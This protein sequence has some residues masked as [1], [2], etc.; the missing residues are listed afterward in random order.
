MQKTDLA[1]RSILAEAFAFTQGAAAIEAAQEQA[2]IAPYQKQVDDITELIAAQRGLGASESQLKDQMSSLADAQEKLNA[3]KS[4]VH[5]QAQADE[6]R[7]LNETS[8]SLTL[9]IEKLGQYTS[10]VLNGA[11]AVRQFNI[12][13]QVQAFAAEEP[14]AERRSTGTVPSKVGR[15]Q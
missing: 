15:G 5:S 1:T 8:N 11:E 6:T 4:A 13:Q 14:A 12:A 3:A 7:S 9:Q 10:A 2:K